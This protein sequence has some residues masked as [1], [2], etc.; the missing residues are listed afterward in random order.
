MSFINSDGRSGYVND[1][2]WFTG[3]AGTYYYVKQ[4]IDAIPPYEFCTDYRQDSGL[5]MEHN[6][7]VIRYDVTATVSGYVMLDAEVMEYGPDADTDGGRA[8]GDALAAMSEHDCVQTPEHLQSVFCRYRDRGITVVAVREGRDGW[9]AHN[10]AHALPN[11]GW[12]IV[13][14]CAAAVADTA[15]QWANGEVFRVHRADRDEVAAMVADGLD[16]EDD[17]D[18]GP[19]YTDDDVSGVYFTDGTPTITELQG[20]F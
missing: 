9:T 5:Y 6:C 13:G 19:E 11:G 16:P 4:D 15:C 1:T 10:T 8:V 20:C 12:L 14:D 17:A 3:A 2:E 18:H 7:T